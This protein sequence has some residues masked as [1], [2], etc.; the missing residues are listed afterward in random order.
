MGSPIV[1]ITGAGSGIGQAL[2]KKYAEDGAALAISDIN[3]TTL[4]ETVAQC[5]ALGAKQIHSQTLDV[6]DEDAW[7]TYAQTVESTLGPATLI[8]NNAGVTVASRADEVSMKDFEWIMNINFWGMVYGTLAFLD[9]IK[10]TNGQIANVSSIFGYFATPTQCTYHASKFAIRGFTESLYQ[11]L[12][13]SHPKVGI[14]TIAPGGIRTNIIRN[15]KILD[16]TLS[17]DQ[18]EFAKN[19]DKIASTSSEAAAKVIFKGLKKRKRHIL[20]GIDAHFLRMLTRLFP[21]QYLN[22]VLWWSR[23]QAKVAA[24]K[25][26]KNAS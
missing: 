20:I 13:L 14:T 3:E 12:K 17:F 24:K 9:Q 6:A 7:K 25:N 23:V 8:I 2:A 16:R 21:S 4:A 11:E 26:K 15:G 1:V 19:F 10:A 18:E 5:E 22:M